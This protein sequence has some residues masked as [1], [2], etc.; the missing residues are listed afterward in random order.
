MWVLAP[1]PVAPEEKQTLFILVSLLAQGAQGDAPAVE[2]DVALMRLPGSI[3]G[4]ALLPLAVALVG[5]E[6]DRFGRVW[7]LCLV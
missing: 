4:I 5:L 6:H 1:C 3:G 2:G 7:L